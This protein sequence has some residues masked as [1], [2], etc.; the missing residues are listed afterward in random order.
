L[1]TDPKLAREKVTTILNGWEGCPVDEPQ[2]SLRPTVICVANFRPEK[3]HDFL[4]ASFLRVTKELPDAQLLLVGSGP[5]ESVLRKV[6]SASDLDGS[7]HFLG[8]VENIWPL[9]SQADVFTLASR[10]E[11]L[12]IVVVEAMAAGL[13]VVA[14]TAGGIPELVNE[15]VTGF[16][17]TR[18]DE[19]S[20][21]NRLVALLRS[22]ELR[23]SMGRASKLAA[24]PLR[25]STMLSRYF[26]LYEK[27]LPT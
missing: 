5:L 22:D 3:G 12:G 25:T 14:T 8:A 1:L 19:A 24:E 7:V 11:P 9:L 17:V 16:L 15:G 27:E 26:D 21:A 13:P 2:K 18:D 23:E 10:F 6:V 20:L 4:I